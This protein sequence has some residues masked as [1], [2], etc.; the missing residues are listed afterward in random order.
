MT[1]NGDEDLARFE[2]VYLERV[3]PTRRLSS[4]PYLGSHGGDG[5]SPGPANLGSHENGGCFS[6]TKIDGI[7]TPGIGFGGL[8]APTI[9]WPLAAAAKK[10]S[11]SAFASLSP[12]AAPGSYSVT[13]VEL[14]PATGPIPGTDISLRSSCTQSRGICASCRAYAISNPNCDASG[15][16]IVYTVT[17]RF[18]FPRSAE[19]KSTNSSLVKSRGLSC[20]NIAFS[21]FTFAEIDLSVN[22]C[23]RSDV[24]NIPASPTSSPNTLNITLIFASSYNHDFFHLP[25]SGSSPTSPTRRTVPEI[26]A[27]RVDEP[28]QYAASEAERSS[29]KMAL[30]PTKEIPMMAHAPAT[31]MPPRVHPSILRLCLAVWSSLVLA[32]VERSSAASFSP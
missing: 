30:T 2:A 11:T 28:S 5:R 3:P 4:E 12:L 13:L 15:S 24:L 18:M 25:D 9:T 6:P 26:I 22:C 17:L 14:I 10:A 19:T 32:M 27:T 7:G 21:V 8:V 29:K 1:A 16:G 31:I 20:F 23:S